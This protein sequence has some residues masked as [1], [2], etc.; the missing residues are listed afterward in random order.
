VIVLAAAVGAAIG[1]LLRPSPSNPYAADAVISIQP[2]TP[3]APDEVARQRGR[4]ERAAQALQL[5]QVLTRAAAITH[6]PVALVRERLSA[7]GNPDSALF[8]IHARG[9]SEREAVGIASAA[10][11]ATIDFLRV[12]SGNPG[13]GSTRTSF[14][15]EGGAQDWGLGHSIFLLPPASTLATTGAAFSGSGFLRTKCTVSRPGCGTWVNVGRAFTP[16]KVYTA[17]AW[18]RARGGPVPLRLGFGSSPEDV[19]DGKTVQVSGRWRRIKVNWTPRSLVGSSEVHVAVNGDGPATFDTDSARVRA[20]SGKLESSQGLDI[21]DRYSLVGP[22]QPSS[23]LRSATASAA[24]VG[25]VIGLAAGAGGLAF[26]W[27]ARR[28][29]HESEQ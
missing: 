22:P 5:P 6:L 12:T 15:F 8:V 2:D 27:L 10:T 9:V 24:L 1:A 7:R 14:D 23:K 19:A 28:R 16:G 21:P 13:A 26:A 4:W 11:T 25:G 3:A 18:V 20:S 29:R 17:T